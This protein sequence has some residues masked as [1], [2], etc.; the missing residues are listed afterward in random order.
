MSIGRLFSICMMVATLV[1][2]LVAGQSLLRETADYRARS[3]A[4]DA[5]YALEALLKVMSSGSIERGPTFTLLASEFEANNPANDFYRRL[6]TERRAATAEAMAALRLKLAAL[7]DPHGIA[8]DQLVGTIIELVD[9]LERERRATRE[10]IDFGLTRPR[11]QRDPN[12]ANTYADSDLQLLR[13]FVPLLNAL[14]ARVATGSPNAA[15]T[16]PLT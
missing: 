13:Y 11:D 10:L 7:D 2:V 3:R 15:S 5:G 8:S 12:L 4:I 6:M 14:Q 9:T 16:N 1:V